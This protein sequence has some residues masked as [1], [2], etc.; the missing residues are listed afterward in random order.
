MLQ[1]D[2]VEDQ[3]VPRLPTVLVDIAF[4]VEI[5]E[6]IVEQGIAFRMTKAIDANAQVLVDE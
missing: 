1:G 2:V 4:G 5:S 3:Q 6:Y